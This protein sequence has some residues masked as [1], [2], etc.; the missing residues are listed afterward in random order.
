[1]RFMCLRVLNSNIEQP[2]YGAEH[3]LH[4]LDVVLMMQADGKLILQLSSSALHA[5]SIHT[6]EVKKETLLA[7]LT[8][9]TVCIY[10]HMYIGMY[11]CMYVCV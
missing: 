9:M 3:T 2:T 11:V 8:I 5:S 7:T 4:V 6:A 10:V 1:M